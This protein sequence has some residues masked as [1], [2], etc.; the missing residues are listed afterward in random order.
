[1]DPEEQ[2]VHECARGVTRLIRCI[3]L[4]EASQVLTI[5]KV[6]T[7][8]DVVHKTDEI[9]SFDAEGSG[10]QG[11]LLFNSSDLQ[12]VFR[13]YTL[14]YQANRYVVFTM[15]PERK[16]A[17]TVFQ[18]LKAYAKAADDQGC[19]MLI[20]TGSDIGAIYNCLDM[21]QS[22]LAYKMDD[23]YKEV[24]AFMKRLEEFKDE[25][26]TLVIMKEDI[27]LSDNAL[28]ALI[29]EMGRR[30]FVMGMREFAENF[31]EVTWRQEDGEGR[32]VVTTEE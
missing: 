9:L 27:F 1:M 17:E 15:E 4:D 10:L 24:L 2:R 29:Y 13:N 3:P 21:S 6:F 14:S 8:G 18:R 32:I 30:V 25:E 12:V 26:A 23:N 31:P 22:F 19:D 7:E 16:Y 5:C 20:F 28:D 11:S